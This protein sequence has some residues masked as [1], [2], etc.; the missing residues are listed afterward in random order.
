VKVPPGKSKITYDLQFSINCLLRNALSVVAQKSV[1]SPTPAF[2]SSS[3]DLSNEC[4][5]KA[6]SPVCFIYE[7]LSRTS[8]FFSS[9]IRSPVVAVFLL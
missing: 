5:A 6:V 8:A 2:T 7:I 3:Q 9:K 1:A 4:C